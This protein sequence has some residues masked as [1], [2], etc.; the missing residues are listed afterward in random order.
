MTLLPCPRSF[1]CF[2]LLCLSNLEG[3]E[4][5]CLRRKDEVCGSDVLFLFFDRDTF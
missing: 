1:A 4:L 2:L 5:G 3:N